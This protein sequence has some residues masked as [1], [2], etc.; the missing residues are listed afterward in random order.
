[1]ASS[2]GGRSAAWATV[3]WALVWAVVLLSVPAAGADV[4]PTGPLPGGGG[5]VIQS[6]GESGASDGWTATNTN[7]E[8]LSAGLQCPPV[9]TLIAPPQ[10]TALTQT[11][12][13]LSDRLGRDGGVPDTPEDARAELTFTADPGTHIS[14]VRY[15]RLVSK[16]D[17]NS[18]DPYVGY[19]AGPML[20]HCEIVAPALGCHVG[21]DDWYPDDEYGTVARPGYA[22]LQNLL[23]SGFVVGL[24]CRTNAPYHHCDNGYSL[25]TAEAEIF[26]IFFTLSDHSKPTVGAPLGEGWTTSEWAQGTLPLALASSD[27]AGILETRLYVDGAILTTVKRLCFYTQP[28]PCTDE[29]GVEIGLP[30]AALADGTHTVQLGAVDAAGNETRLTRPEPLRSDNHAPDP[31]VGAEPVGGWRTASGRIDLRWALPVDHGTPIVEARYEL[32]AGDTCSPARPT[33]TLTSLDDLQL[34]APSGWVVR[35]WLVDAAGHADPA[36]AASVHVYREYP[37]APSPPSPPPPGSPGAGGTPVPTPKHAAKLRLAHVRRTGRTLRL[38][39]TLTSR[40]SGRVTVRLTA[41]GTRRLARRATVRRGRFALT[42]TL[43][44]ALARAATATL[45]A[46]YPGDADTAAATARRTLH[47]SRARRR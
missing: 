30:T 45:T 36:G 6:C 23:A 22:D 5:F 16:A 14:R 34:P 1:V 46:T 9:R 19:A 41:R 44:R 35:I 38:T 28:R 40:A 12:L 26:S 43:P 4:F 3:A 21:A 31:P 39:G 24:H 37:T 13:W 27:N 8:A 32:C 11:G 17:D 10:T 33:T 2:M 29:P 42:L 7:P 15:W 20:D 18:W 47:R 25:R